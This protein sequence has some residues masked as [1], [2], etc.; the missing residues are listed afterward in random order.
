MAPE[1]EHEAADERALALA[2]AIEPHR[3][4]APVSRDA[5]TQ[6]RQID[7][8]VGPP[9]PGERVQ[10]ATLRPRGREAEGTDEAR[11]VGQR[12]GARCRRR[13]LHA[14]GAERRDEHAEAAAA[15][16]HEPPT[17]CAARRSARAAIASVGLAVPRP[18]STA[19]LRT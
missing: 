8:R 12:L 3:P 16:P 10:Q 18:G 14:A 2:Q 9:R 1:I 7:A 4:L 6:P 15:E 17:R 13:R 19:P 5:I 11:E